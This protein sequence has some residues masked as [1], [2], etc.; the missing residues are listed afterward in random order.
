MAID[1]ELVSAVLQSEKR[2]W[3]QSQEGWVC[4]ICG[5][6]AYIHDNMNI[7]ACLGE[8]QMFIFSPST[9]FAQKKQGKPA[10]IEPLMREP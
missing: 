2:D 8:C 4:N 1:A 7:W 9:F 3:K 10:Q 5:D 6:P